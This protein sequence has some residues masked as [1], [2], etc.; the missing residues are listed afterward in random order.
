MAANHPQGIKNPFIC[1]PQY[2]VGLVLIIN[3][4]K[5]AIDINDSN[6][7]LFLVVPSYVMFIHL[8]DTWSLI[9]DEK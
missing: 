1:I 5:L 7:T 9:S 4:N 8:K 3:K 6:T 2:T